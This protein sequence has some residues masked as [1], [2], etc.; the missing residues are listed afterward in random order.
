MMDPEDLIG[1]KLW[2][3]EGHLT[4]LAA[5]CLT[6]DELPE[7]EVSRMRGHVR[8]CQPCR[9]AFAKTMRVNRFFMPDPKDS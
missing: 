8:S 4:A 1:L 5:S 9:M 7:P 2:T 3:A 6:D